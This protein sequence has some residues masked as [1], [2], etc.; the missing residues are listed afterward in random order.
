M[1]SLPIDVFMGGEL[2]SLD[3][4]REDHLKDVLEALKDGGV[5]VLKDAIDS[6]EQ[7]EKN[8][9]TVLPIP[10]FSHSTDH[11]HSMWLQF[12]PQQ[13]VAKFKPANLYDT[14]NHILPSSSFPSDV[15]R[16]GRS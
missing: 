8:Q 12:L 1:S 4:S 2:V 11:P 5:V 6:N 13:E 10:A 3:F 14:T 15:R 7:A 9:V 16:I